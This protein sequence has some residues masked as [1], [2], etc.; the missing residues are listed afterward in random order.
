MT[1]RGLK[2]VRL[3][4]LVFL[5]EARFDD[6]L[7]IGSFDPRPRAPLVTS[8]IGHTLSQPF[9]DDRSELLAS[10]FH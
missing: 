10:A 4:E 1:F 9:F 5:G 6:V 2:L 7:G 3:P 8:M